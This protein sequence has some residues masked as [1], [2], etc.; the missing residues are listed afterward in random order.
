MRPSFCS[1]RR[2]GVDLVDSCSA[3][4]SWASP[5]GHPSEA[6]A[7]ANGLAAVWSTA[8]RAGVDRRVPQS[9][10]RTSRLAHHVVARS[11]R[12]PGGTNGSRRQPGAAALIALLPHG[13]VRRGAPEEAS[14]DRD[15]A[16]AAAGRGGSRQPRGRAGLVATGA[17]TGCA[18]SGPRACGSSRGRG[19]STS[20]R[21][22]S[23]R[24]GSS[25]GGQTVAA[26][27][28]TPPR[29][30][31]PGR[32][33]GRAAAAAGRGRAARARAG[34]LLDRRLLALGR[35]CPRLRPGTGKPPQPGGAG[36]PR[37]GWRAGG[38]WRYVPGHW[39]PR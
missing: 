31:R 26:P 2:I 23:R 20:R 38:A 22:G 10:A 32:D 8:L 16:A 28:A 33:G 5:H 9:A 21:A 4:A 36:C 18:T 7:T 17:G 6:H 30:R 12:H 19:R 15:P 35:R 34:L 27:I 3:A 13:A 37:T 24:R 14:A 11:P 25:P 39:A 29:R 1:T